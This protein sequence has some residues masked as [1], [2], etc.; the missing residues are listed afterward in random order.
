[1]FLLVH[2]IRTLETR[3]SQYP[4]PGFNRK[5]LP[6]DYYFAGTDYFIDTNLTHSL[7]V[8]KIHV[9]LAD[10]L[11]SILWVCLPAIIVPLLL[12]TTLCVRI[13]DCRM[14]KASYDTN[15]EEE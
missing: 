1:M 12:S 8:R 10:L 15:A 5:G 2:F 14:R 7:P 11:T 13:D 4:N 6:S 9:P 3:L